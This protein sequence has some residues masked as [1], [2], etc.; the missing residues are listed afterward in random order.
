[1]N[2]AR[3]LLIGLTL[4]ALALSG[5]AQAR[6]DDD[7]SRTHRDGARVEGAAA[8][9][10][11]QHRDRGQD[12]RSGRFAHGDRWDRH[13]YGPRHGGRIDA[14]QDR[15]RHRIHRGW[16]AGD[17]NRGEVRQLGRQ[18][19]RI[20]KMEHRFAADGHLSRHERRHLDHA[21]DRASRQIHRARHDDVYRADRFAYRDGHD[22]WGRHGH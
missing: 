16:H 5:A 10:P 6:G 9:R 12:S 11:E 18:Q 2:I 17:L 3:H 20:D 19:R 22:R 7:R 4:G 8:K 13:G 14:R 15:Q 1:M 21:Q